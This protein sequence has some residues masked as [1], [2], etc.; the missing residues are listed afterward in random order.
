MYHLW[1]NVQFQKG[2]WAHHLPIK[3]SSPRDATPTLRRDEHDRPQWSYV[4]RH[5]HGDRHS[6][7][8]MSTCA[9]SWH[10]LDNKA[11]L[12]SYVTKSVLMAFKEDTKLALSTWNIP[13][14]CR[15]FTITLRHTTLGRTPLDEWSARCRDLYLT[16]HRHPCPRWDSKPQTQQ[17]NGHRPTS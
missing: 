13:S 16:T 2:T 7:V 15:G 4:T 8:H 9:Q 5:R 1:R 14:S 3:Q 11:E 12:L 17:A 10:T 6:W